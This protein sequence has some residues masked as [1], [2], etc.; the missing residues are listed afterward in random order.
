VY[1]AGT[2]SGNPLALAAGLAQL[3]E[4]EARDGWTHLE[5]LG[6]AYEA[7]VR[8]ALKRHGLPFQFQR[9][10]SMFCLYFTADPVRDLASAQKSDRARFAKFFHHC[11]ENGVYFAP[12][13]FEAGF[14]SMAH[15][16]DD[17]EKTA[18]VT[19]QALAAI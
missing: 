15:T 6:A 11:R 9:I 12:S 5:T 4:L 19:A 3:R 16:A 2:L 13:Q 10:G 14:L 8:S 17:L 1:Q 7:Q 18:A